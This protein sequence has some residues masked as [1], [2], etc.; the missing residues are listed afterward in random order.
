MLLAGTCLFLALAQGRAA[1]GPLAQTRDRAVAPRKLFPQ[2]TAGIE[3][4][5]GQLVMNCQIAPDGLTVTDRAWLTFV[6]QGKG[7]RWNFNQTPYTE[8]PL[9]NFRFDEAFAGLQVSITVEIFDRAKPWDVSETYQEVLQLGGVPRDLPEWFKL[10]QD[11]LAYDFDEGTWFPAGWQLPRGK[12]ACWEGAAKYNQ[13]DRHGRHPMLDFGFTQVAENTLSF[14]GHAPDWEHQCRVFGDAEWLDMSDGSNFKTWHNDGWKHRGERMKIVIPDFENGGQWNWSPQHFDAFRAMVADFKRAR[15]NCLFGCW[16]VGVTNASLRIFDHVDDQGRPTGSVHLVAAKQWRD[17]Y[18][19]PEKELNPIF[20]RCELTFG[21]PSVYWLNGGNPAHL[22]AVVQEW[23]IGERA[24][25]KTPNVVSAWIQTEFVDKY[26]LS[27]YRFKKPD[28]TYQW[29]GI[30]HQAPPSL[31]YA[32][33]LFAHCRMDGA[34]CWET[35]AGYSEDVADAGEPAEGGG[36]TPVRKTVNNEWRDVY[37][38]LKYFGFYNYHVLGMW[39]AS[40]NKDIIEASSEWFMPEF[41]TSAGKVWRI[42]DERY[43]S[44]CSFYKEPL[45]RAKKSAD[46]SEWLVIACNP[47]NTGVQK[48]ALRSPDAAAPMEF[49][50]I[51]DY[52]AIKRFRVKST[53]LLGGT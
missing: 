20:D 45:V 28:G 22:Y 2:I 43:P 36:Q 47:Y 49:E 14:G 8:Q 38:Y 13:Q 24:R 4:A 23:E 32:M 33:S 21:N 44:F 52:P 6:P 31:V 7:K 29:R 27:T 17:K 50:L 41:R 10:P 34:Y 5:Q 16:G 25:P 48:V 1:D 35:G 19:R 51:G 42:G 3:N 15:P 37:Y 9:V 26:P 40:Q 30:K 11:R 12:F 39:H 18:E 46:G 53:P